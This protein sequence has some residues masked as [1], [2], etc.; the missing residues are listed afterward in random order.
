MMRCRHIVF[1]IVLYGLCI[2]CSSD[3]PTDDSKRGEDGKE[4]PLSDKG[5]LFADFETYSTT[6]YFFRYGNSGGSKMNNY[7]PRWI[8]SHVVT[9]NPVKNEENPSSKVL[10]YTSMEARNYGLKFRFSKAADINDVR[11][12]RLKI[13]Q[14]ANVIEKE[15]W[16]GTSKATSQQLGVKLIGRF[17]SV[18]DYKQEEGILL[19][20]SLVDFKEEGV[21]KTYTF[22]FSKSEYG[23]AA[24]QMKNGIAGMVIL[25]TY[26]SGV[27]LTEENKYKCYID[28]IEILE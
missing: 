5:I 13:Y 27:T 1:F 4:E 23:V 3:G 14:P 9:D 11:G 22:T 8:Y 28:D 25:P 16:K 18:N 7:Y 26:G 24:I 17:N 2:T 21:W 12:I 19:T 6:P 10:E 15:T 20:N